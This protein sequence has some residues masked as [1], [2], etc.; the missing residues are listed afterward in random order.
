MKNRWQS[1]LII[2]LLA[3]LLT[4]LVRG[5]MRENIVAPM[6]YLVWIGQ[7]IFESIPQM[8]IWVVFLIVA[9]VMAIRSLFVKKPS[10]SEVDYAPKDRATRIGDWANLL[11]RTSKDVYYRWQLA[12]SLQR[13]TLETLA[14]NERTTIKEMRQRVTDGEM[15][16]PPEI[17]AYLQAGMVSIG[18]F[19]EPKSRFRLRKQQ[20]TPLDL[21]PELVIQFLE[22]QIDHHP[23]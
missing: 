11:Q 3:S 22:D 8:A 12:H 14:H 16:I 2:L 5:A 20:P 18:H 7:L 13:L 4:L 23:D 6:L 9:L 10:A 19:S 1:L 17:Q 15:D 21:N